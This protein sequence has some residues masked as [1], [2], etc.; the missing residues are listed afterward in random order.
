MFGLGTPEIIILLGLFAFW[1]WSLV[2]CVM[3]ESSTGNDRVVWLLVILC[4]HGFGALI[5]FFVRRPKRI[6]ELGH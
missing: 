2:D 4:G 1:A 5:Y 3:N 6:T